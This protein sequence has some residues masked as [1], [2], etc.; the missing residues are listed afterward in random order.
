[1]ATLTAGCQVILG[2]SCSLDFQHALHAMPVGCVAPVSSRQVCASMRRSAFKAE[3]Q[4]TVACVAQCM[5]KQK[6]LQATHRQQ[7]VISTFELV[8]KSK[9][10]AVGFCSGIVSFQ[11]D[12]QSFAIYCGNNQLALRH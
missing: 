5:L 6:H 4:L 7:I 8:F 11:R 3:K 9:V 1:M 10:Q 2:S 12:L